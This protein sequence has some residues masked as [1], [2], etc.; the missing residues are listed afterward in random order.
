MYSFSLLKTNVKTTHLRWPSSSNNLKAY[1]K[2]G[3]HKITA[4][5]QRLEGN[6]LIECYRILF[7]HK[8]SQNMLIII[9][10][11][12]WWHI[13]I[14]IYDWW[15]IYI[16]YQHE[17]NAINHKNYKNNLKYL[18]H[19]EISKMNFTKMINGNMRIATNTIVVRY[20][21]LPTNKSIMSLKYTNL[22]TCI[23]VRYRLLSCTLHWA[24]IKIILKLDFSWI[25]AYPT[26]CRPVW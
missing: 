9:M 15:H 2:S 6:T 20:S 4:N 10:Q 19:I 11:N 17:L 3:L 16:W 18:S 24:T 21:T 23:T 13:Y 14:Y 25:S 26:Y 8:I 22:N 7:H 12:N 5:E 1:W